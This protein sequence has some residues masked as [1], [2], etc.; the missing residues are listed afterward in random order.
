MNESDESL[1]R[2]YSEG[3]I[4]SFH[5]LYSRIAPRWYPIVLNVGRNEDE[6][7]SLFLWLFEEVHLA[8]GSFDLNIGFEAWIKQLL[9]KSK[10]S[11]LAAAYGEKLMAPSLKFTEIVLDWIDQQILPPKKTVLSRYLS[12][13]LVIGLFV[14]FISRVA[15]A[16][17]FEDRSLWDPDLGLVTEAFARGAILGLLSFLI[18]L[19]FL[20]KSERLTLR[21]TRIWIVPSTV[22]LLVFIRMLYV[23]FVSGVLLMPLPMTAWA[24]GILMSGRLAT[25]FHLK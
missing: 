17:S 10:R 6:Q 1:M 14:E 16:L 4:E 3:D 19:F 21:E 22:V 9:S 8:R 2:K 5:L 24:V 11:E 7:K 23:Y 18:P 25:S 12:L 13:V 20:T 15:I